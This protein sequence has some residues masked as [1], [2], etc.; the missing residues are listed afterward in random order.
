M[1]LYAVQLNMLCYVA[2]TKLETG[3]TLNCH[4]AV[5]I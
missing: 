4:M 1:E 3:T 5:S 2:L